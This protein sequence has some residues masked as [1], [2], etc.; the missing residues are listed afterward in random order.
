MSLQFILGNSG[1]GKSTY[2]YEQVLEEARRHPDKN[3]LILV[4]EQ[5]TMSTQRELVRLQ[6]AHAI[7][8]VDVLSFARLAYRV[9]DELGQENLM[10]LEE[11]GKNL[12]LRKIAEEKKADLK[13]LGSNMNKMGYIGEVKS[14][15][16][17]LS[18]YN[19]TPDVL[20]EFLSCAQISESLRRKLEDI[21]TLY[22]G[23]RKFLE[24]R[25]ITS[26]E[27]LTLLCEVAEES[28]MIR[29][30]VIVFDEFT[31]FTPIQN[32][33]LA[34]LLTVAEKLMVSVTMDYREDFYHCRG[35]HELFAMSKKTVKSLISMADE[36]HV[37]VEEPVVL[38]KGWRYEQSKVSQESELFFM[39]QNLFRPWSKKWQGKTEDIQ[40]SLH[41][42]PKEE[43]FYVANEI[44]A[45]VR[46]ENYRYEDIAVVTGD[47]NLYA[48]YVS[49]VFLPYEIPFFV[50]LS[51]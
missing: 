1:S 47:V 8:N 4:P 6:K 24:G 29:D 2:L 32:R 16:S 19:I 36:L 22:S 17:E 25:F 39:E 48:N 44:A 9:F 45:L 43:L 34:K 3:Y 30:S 13:V 38:K 15:I 35:D 21:L 7:M 11:T 41:R 50:D 27:I 37:Q 14:L 18:Q 49:E 20:Q 26:E 40:L 10:V 5:F 33:L 12:V 31:G 46:N 23:F 51:L 42:N 28:A